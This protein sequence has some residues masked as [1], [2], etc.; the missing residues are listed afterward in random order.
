MVAEV[1]QAEQIL[2][3]LSAKAYVLDTR[4]EK[5]FQTDVVLRASEAFGKAGILRP[6]HLEKAGAAV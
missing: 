6:R 2:I 3:Q 5:D 4:F 1:A